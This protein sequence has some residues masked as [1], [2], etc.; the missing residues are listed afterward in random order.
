M[1]L[2]MVILTNWNCYFILITSRQ[3]GKVGSKGGAILSWR[4][5]GSGLFVTLLLEIN[6]I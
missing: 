3:D 4:I 6:T 5:S 1:P 2:T